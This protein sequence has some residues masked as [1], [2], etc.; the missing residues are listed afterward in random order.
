MIGRKLAHY[1]V[2]ERLG[3]GGMG[4]V[5]LARDEHLGRDVALKILPTE[6][7]ADPKRVLRF[8]R[9][10]HLASQLSHAN[11]ATIHDSAEADGLH[12]IAMELVRG[13]TLAERV[14]PGGLAL[15]A[16]LDIA[17]PLAE[18]LEE[19]H[20]SG[21]LHRDL[22]PANVMLDERGRVKILDFGLSRPL[23]ESELTAG[24]TSSGKV[25]GTPHYMSPEQMRGD[26]VD[27]RSDL[28][29]LGVVL[30]E[31]AT[32]VRPF[33]GE[34]LAVVMNAVLESQPPPI[35]AV[36]PH[37]G[38][39]FAHTVE[40]LL[41]KD[42]GQRFQ[43]AAG[44][45]ADLRSLKKP[46]TTVVAARRRLAP[47]YVLAGLGLLVLAIG[48]F[49]ALRPDRSGTG[50][51][52]VAVV[53]AAEKLTLAIVP[54]SIP[55]DDETAAAMA[56][57]LVHSLPEVLGIPAI[58]LITARWLRGKA[59]HRGIESD[60]LD[61]VTATE[62]AREEGADVILIGALE[63]GLQGLDVQIELLDTVTGHY[64]TSQYIPAVTPSGVPGYVDEMGRT[65]LDA[66]GLSPAK[67]G[68]EISSLSDSPRALELW[69][70][71]PKTT[72][73]YP[74]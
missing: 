21:V 13:E 59:K 5:Y 1:T 33:E 69:A 30:Y 52:R 14:R 50:E 29:A 54:F 37:V 70:D 49:Y 47:G 39:L 72:L 73:Q 65:I 60:S 9:E 10:A 7:A 17:V 46:S 44:L 16:I 58:D 40:R 64:R 51:P 68:E 12:F 26:Q 22:K 25:M 38:E 36:N 15:D 62:I 8:H 71:T 66:L 19:A 53:P 45:A 74:Q 56:R 48:G 27:A 23:E 43:S 24:L 35:L 18:G 6:L 11:I 57:T 28:F 61:P 20:R 31:L 34:S 3:A 55:D 41:G 63:H 42:P 67:E 2:L 32:G 4:E